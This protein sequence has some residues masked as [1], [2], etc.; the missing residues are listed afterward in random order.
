MVKQLRFSSILMLFF[1]KM[2]TKKRIYLFFAILF[3][4]NILIMRNDN[5]IIPVRAADCYDL[6]FDELNPDACTA[7]CLA[8]DTPVSDNPSSGGV[9]QG[10]C[11]AY[12]YGLIVNS[13]GTDCIPDR[14]GNAGNSVDSNCTSGLM[15]STGYC[16]SNMVDYCNDVED[17][18]KC[19]GTLKGTT[20]EV[21]SDCTPLVCNLDG[22]C[23][24]SVIKTIG[25]SISGLT[26]NVSINGVK[27]GVNSDGKMTFAMGVKIG[28]STVPAGSYISNGNIYRPDGVMI[29]G[30]NSADFLPAGG[31]PSFP[32]SSISC[33]AGFESFAGVCFPSQEKVP[34]SGTTIF[35][36]LSKLLY[37]LLAIFGVLALAA[38]VISGIQYVLASG[39]EDLAETAKHN[40]TNAIIGI[41]LGLSGFIILRAIAAALSGSLSMF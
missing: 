11:D 30:M 23:G 34:L 6:C 31:V 12:G 8:Q 38:F 18:A 10:K 32:G 2:K 41:V 24:Q 14:S 28:E 5:I 22:T 13:A 20:C 4:A 19:G 26:D 3:F 40:A 27:F 9:T 36:I 7:E 29:P 16:Y 1:M 39:N 33:E 17:P 37:W 21:D 15:D 35:A 25:D